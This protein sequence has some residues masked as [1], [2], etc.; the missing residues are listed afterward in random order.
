MLF[1][2]GLIGDIIYAYAKID[3]EDFKLIDWKFSK[4]EYDNNIQK[5]VENV[6]NLDEDHFPTSHFIL[7]YYVNKSKTNISFDTSKRKGIGFVC[8]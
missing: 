8:P 3:E 6:D 4:N 5:I 1:S 7:W 2:F